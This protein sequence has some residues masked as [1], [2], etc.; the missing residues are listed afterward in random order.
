M[1]KRSPQAEQPNPQQLKM[2]YLT[3]TAY[4]DRML[5][6]KLPHILHVLITHKKAVKIILS[7]ARLLLGISLNVYGFANFKNV[8]LA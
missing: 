8:T 2:K 3:Y 6:L 4:T 1:P 7:E 5:L